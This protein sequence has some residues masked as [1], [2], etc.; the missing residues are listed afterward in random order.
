MFCFVFGSNFEYIT[1]PKQ[2]VEKIYRQTV[3]RKLNTMDH[4]KRMHVVNLHE[5][6][7]VCFCVYVHVPHAAAIASNDDD[8]DGKR[9]RLRSQ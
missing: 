7:I 9:H 4:R 2:Y 5:H 3:C 6:E 1:I 8:D